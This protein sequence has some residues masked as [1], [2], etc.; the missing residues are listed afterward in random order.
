MTAT[1]SNSSMT[2]TAPGGV[3]N[4]IV[5]ELV[6]LANTAAEP[7]L[8][9]TSA[10]CWNLSAPGFIIDPGF[11]PFPPSLVPP[12]TIVVRSS[13]GGTAT[14]TGTAIKQIACVSTLKFTCP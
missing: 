10:P 11:G 4:P 5:A 14:V 12:T 7:T 2:P 3:D 1:I 13:R 9:P 6:Q 8:C